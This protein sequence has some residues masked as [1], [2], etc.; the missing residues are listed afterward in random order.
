MSRNPR[1]HITRRTVL[2][3]AATAGLAGCSALGSTQQQQW[4]QKDA[5]PDDDNRNRECRIGTI[6]PGTTTISAEPFAQSLSG[7]EDMHGTNQHY[8]VQFSANSPIDIYVSSQS[9]AVSKFVEVQFQGGTVQDQPD[10][11]NFSHLEEYARTATTSYEQLI[12][13]PDGE[14]Y[15]VIVAGANREPG[16]R[17]MAS[18]PIGVEYSFGCSYYLSF[19]EYKSLRSDN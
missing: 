10:G 11:V 12:Q 15:I 13:V 16:S 5:Y 3:L 19:S 2:S 17:S 9:D 6:D 8:K 18:E 7:G 1:N 14:S 4:K